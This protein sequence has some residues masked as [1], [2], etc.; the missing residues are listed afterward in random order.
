MLILSVRC[1]VHGCRLAATDWISKTS[2]PINYG[3][4][5]AV[6]HKGV[7]VGIMDAWLL[8]LAA[9]GV[10]SEMLWMKSTASRTL[11]TSDQTANESIY[12]K[13]IVKIHPQI[14]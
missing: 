14:K 10:S 3:F 13:K 2:Q 7:P 9:A 6:V 12:G 4:I 1:H 5:N 8:M 11:V